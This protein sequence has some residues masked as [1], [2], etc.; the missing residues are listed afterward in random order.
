MLH[1]AYQAALAF[2]QHPLF[3]HTLCTADVPCLVLV[4]G[5]RQLQPRLVGA[6]QPLQ[7]VPLAG[8]SQPATL[9]KA[10]SLL[11]HG[12]RVQAGPAYGT[13]HDGKG[14][15]LRGY[16]QLSIHCLRVTSDTSCI[17]CGDKSLDS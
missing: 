16:G 13:M 6:R 9:F 11:P 3:V 4:V 8:R 17:A 2:V 15:W 1:Q 14:Q 12:V 10:T 5:E 7:P